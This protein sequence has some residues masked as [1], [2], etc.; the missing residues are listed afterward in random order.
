MHEFRNGLNSRFESC[1][2]GDLTLY[3]ATTPSKESIVKIVTE[4]LYNKG[5]EH[6]TR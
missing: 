6:S 2:V 1:G 4:G 3:T 5:K